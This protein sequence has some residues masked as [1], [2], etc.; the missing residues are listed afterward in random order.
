MENTIIYRARMIRTMNPSLPVADTVVVRGSRILEVGTMETVR[1][2]FGEEQPEV[3]DRFRDSVLMPGFIDPHV[4]PGMAS[5]LLQ[6]HWITALDWRRPDGDVTAVRGQN[7]FLSRLIEIESQLPADEPLVSWGYHELW[8]GALTGEVL[9]RISQRR[10]II[11]WHRGYHSLY[12][13]DAAMAWLDITREDAE[14]HPQVDAD[15][16][17]FYESGMSLV[18]GRLRKYFFAPD[19][20]KSG[21]QKFRNVVHA[22]GITTVGDMAFGGF[23]GESVEWQICQSMFDETTPF[24]VQ[25]TP[26]AVPVGAGIDSGRIDYP[27]R[28]AELQSF[29]LAKKTSRLHFGKS[30]KFLADGGFFSN[31]MQLQWPGRIDG[32]DGEWMTSPEVLRE[33]V[34]AFW[35]AGFVI[36]V[37]TSADLGFELVLDILEDLQARRPRAGRKFVIEHLGVSTPEQIQRAAELGANA[38][39]NIFYL[40]ELGDRYWKHVLG[41]ERASQMSR[42]GTLARNNIR[43]ALHSDFSMA[44]AA[45]LVNAWVAVNRLNENGRVMGEHER[46]SIEQAMKAI[47]IDAAY[48]LGLDSEIGSIRSGKKADFTVLDRDPF[49]TPPERL[50]DIKVLG[51]VFEGQYFPNS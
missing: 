3:D 35:N 30:V 38:S 20:M 27:A 46:I 10:P 28:I 16:Q 44:P 5:M 9:T 47:T 26:L 17:F 6:M 43:F 13:N 51:S 34:E 45:P 15:K 2:W 14:K 37:H 40:H 23:G 49:E 12:I 11:V 8:H 39:I 50:R 22:G 42:A 21:Y 33:A 24:R 31:L 48:I 19:R 18:T 7:E 1:A 4:H 32:R 36:H 29:R 41:Y 25:L